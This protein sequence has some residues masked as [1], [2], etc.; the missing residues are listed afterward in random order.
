LLV[1]DEPDLLALLQEALHGSHECLLAR[2]ADEARAVFTRQTVDLI[3]TDHAMPGTTG[4]ELL[5]WVRLYSPHTV[6]LL[7]SGL[8]GREDI[9]DAVNRGHIYYFLSKPW[10][11]E[12]V[13][14]AVRNAVEKIELERERDQLLSQLR[15]WGANLEERV[16]DRTR[17]LE[18]AH[19]ELQQQAEELKRLALT[20][21]L[22][23]LFNRRAVD[24]LAEVEVK[25]HLRYQ[26]P[27]TLALIDVDHFR[28]INRVYLHPGGD[29]VLQGLARVLT[30]SVREVVDS[31]GRVGGE[32]FLI[33]ARETGEDGAR[34]LAERIRSTVASSPM[35]YDGKAISLTVSLGIAVA[36][37]TLCPQYPELYALAATALRAA[38][39]AG[40][41]RFVLRR[42]GDGV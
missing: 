30:A 28:E 42:V 23:G 14:Q 10:R 34:V 3:L 5:E 38:K 41:N 25:R 35:V 16:A 1:D 9:I 19:R 29:A 15:Q 18:Q 22:T 31:V 11:A 27:L 32:E 13:V 24:S 4:V 33:I 20:D 36:E 6:R 40:R 39:D 37:S 8:A 12:E 26:N 21:P 2:S 7:M 17:E